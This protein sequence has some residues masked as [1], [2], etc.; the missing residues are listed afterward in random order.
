MKHKVYYDEENKVMVLRVIGEYTLEDAE[1]TT[2]VMEKI[3]E[4]KGIQ[5]LMADLTQTPPKLDKKVREM[6][7]EQAERYD[8]GK[9]ALVIT[10]PAVRMIG[11]IVISTMG[12]GDT[13]RFFKTDEEALA[14][15]KGDGK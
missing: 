5:S 13:T 14:W 9:M 11:K 15:L 2:R 10:N 7:R 1:E 12:S 6:M 4:E 8:L 3:T